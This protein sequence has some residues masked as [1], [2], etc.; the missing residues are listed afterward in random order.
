MN[1][2]I[3]WEEHWNDEH[4]APYYVNIVTGTRQWTAPL[5]PPPPPRPAEW[6]EQESAEPAPTSA[7]LNQREPQPYGVQQPWERVRVSGAVGAG[8]S[9][10]GAATADSSGTMDLGSAPSVPKPRPPPTPKAVPATMEMTPGP[11][12]PNE[13]GDPVYAAAFDWTLRSS[14]P[15]SGPYGPPVGGSAFPSEW[16]GPHAGLPPSPGL[17]LRKVSPWFL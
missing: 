3:G 16:D 6:D 1:L 12:K 14:G 5:V 10:A 17:G 9:A 15:A 13:V 4:E 2:P 11:A 7:G 8:S